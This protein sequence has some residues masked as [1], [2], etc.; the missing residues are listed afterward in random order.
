MKANC[1]GVLTLVLIG[2]QRKPPELPKPI[3][4]SES[5]ESKSVTDLGEGKSQ[6]GSVTFKGAKLEVETQEDSLSQTEEQVKKDIYNGVEQYWEPLAEIKDLLVI[7]DQFIQYEYGPNDERNTLYLTEDKKEVFHQ[8]TG[9]AYDIV[10][11]ERNYNEVSAGIY[12]AGATELRYA[13]MWNRYP[14]PEYLEHNAQILFG[15]QVRDTVR[16]LTEEGEDKLERLISHYERSRVSGDFTEL[17]LQELQWRFPVNYPQP[18]PTAV[19][20]PL[21]IF[22]EY[23]EVFALP[24]FAEMPQWSSVYEEQMLEIQRL[25][26][27]QQVVDTVRLDCVDALKVYTLLGRAPLELCVMEQ[28]AKQEI[29]YIHYPGS[30]LPVK[31]KQSQQVV[32][33]ALEQTVKGIQ[34]WE[35]TEYGRFWKKEATL[36]LRALQYDKMKAMRQERRDANL[37]ALDVSLWD[38]TSQEVMDESTSTILDSHVSQLERELKILRYDIAKLSEQG[39]GNQARQLFVIFPQRLQEWEFFA[40][41]CLFAFPEDHQV[42]TRMELA[43]LETYTDL[44]IALDA[45]VTDVTKSS[46]DRWKTM[47]V[48]FTNGLMTILDDHQGLTDVQRSRLETIKNPSIEVQLPQPNP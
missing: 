5:S 47:I 13:E 44:L 43:L 24:P 11:A 23:R 45:S 38:F 42:R 14:T 25:S 35:E 17:A 39:V 18:I 10:V 32:F 26:N 46:V 36:R 20:S 16:H 33:K 6:V 7:Y 21:A 37:I 28:L 19:Q 12:I 2:C 27:G 4:S 34:E 3:A 48:P 1:F 31:M 15:E 22:T 9:S 8:L 29:L 41:A 30:K 40:Q